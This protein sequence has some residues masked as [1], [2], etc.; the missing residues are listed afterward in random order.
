LDQTVFDCID[1]LLFVRVVSFSEMEDSSRCPFLSKSQAP[2]KGASA[3]QTHCQAPLNPNME[4]KP[5][6]EAE[7]AMC[8]KELQAIKEA[9]GW[10]EP[11]RGGSVKEGAS[12]AEGKPIQWRFGAPPDYTLANLEYFKYKLKHHPSGS[13]EQLVENLVKTWEFERSHKADPR[14]HTVANQEGFLLSANGGKK[15]SHLEA[16][17]VGNYNALLESC[18]SQFWDSEKMSNWESHE[19]FHAVFPAFAWEILKVHTG[20]PVVHFEWRH[21]GRFTGIYKNHRGNGEMIDLRGHGIAT[22]SDKLQLMDTQFF[23]DQE[24][25]LKVLEGRLPAQSLGHPV[26]PQ[27][28]CIRA[29]DDVSNYADES[30]VMY[31]SP[32]DAV[33]RCM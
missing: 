14:Q 32:V 29:I 26:D 2:P 12:D 9:T 17:E 4:L 11:D 10:D 18:D 3:M 15:F 6:S 1:P 30:K 7:Q 25:F 21:F 5:L 23:Y 28:T 13:L 31:V 20:P 19:L 27:R 22:V 33:C 8:K 24:T 16:H